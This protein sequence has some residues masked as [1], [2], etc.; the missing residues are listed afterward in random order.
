MLEGK[1]PSRWIGPPVERHAQARHTTTNSSALA[2]LVAP[3]S[4]RRFL[5]EHWPQRVFFGDGALTRLPSLFCSPELAS[6]RALTSQ[7]RGWLGFGRGSLS[8]RMVSVQQVNPDHLYAMGLSVYLPD[9]EASVN[10]ASAFLRQLEAELGIAEGSARITVWASPKGDGASTHFD[11]EDVFSIQ[12]A[13]TKRFEVAPMRE[14]ANP[15]GT[16]FSPGAPA[17]DDMYPQIENGFPNIEGVQFEA[18]DMKPGSVLFVPRGTW[19]R[20]SAAQ[21]SL[22]VSVV[23]NPPTVAESFLGQLRHVLLQDP[24]WRQPLYGMHGPRQQVDDAL[25][26]ILETAGRAVEA[27]SPRDLIPA[28]D[29]ERLRNIDRTTRFQRDAGTRIVF[30]QGAQAR[31]L[32]VKVPSLDNGEQSTLKMHVPD[33]YALIMR[34]LAESRAAFSAGELHDRFAGVAFEQHC[35]IL[36]VLTRAKYL[37]VLWFPQLPKA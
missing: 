13:G 28:S 4:V 19:H 6:F 21:D 15:V 25:K 14:Y 35:K 8:P 1:I 9:V 3:L 12:L 20:T 22:A 17:Y 10:G 26:R 32:E 30:G 16:Q 23:I 31:M 33:E 5:N 7:Y 34:W 2:A 24:Q 18:Y 27:I 29:G 11:G 37:R 36:D